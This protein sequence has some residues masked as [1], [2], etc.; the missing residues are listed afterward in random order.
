MQTQAWKRSRR[1][2]SGRA[3]LYAEAAQDVRLLHELNAQRRAP[4]A[5]ARRRWHGQCRAARERDGAA[6]HAL[7]LVA[8]HARLAVGAQVERW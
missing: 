7:Q 3:R 1:C 4:P 8:Q 6:V 5:E 2:R